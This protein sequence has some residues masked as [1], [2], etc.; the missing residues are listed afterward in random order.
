MMRRSGFLLALLC[1]AVLPGCNRRPLD[2]Q[3]FRTKV[4]VKVN[5]DAVS[6]V[7]CDIYN[8]KIPL[9]MIDPEVMRVL[10]FEEGSGAL[11]AE[12][13]ISGRS[14]D[15][16]DGKT[17]FSGE[18][19]IAPGSYRLLAYNFGT[20][21]TQ[22]RDPYDWERSEAY[23][24]PVP[25]SI[26]SKFA[27]KVPEGETV[28]YEPDHLVVARVPDEVIPPHKG[29]YTIKT[30]CRSV[31]ES[32]YLQI[33]VDGLQWVSSA[34]AVLSGLSSG[35]WISLGQRIDDPRNAVCFSLLKSD[36]KGEP[37]VC[38]I[39]STFG[40]PDG[41]QN[42]LEVTFDLRTTD[43]RTIQKSFDISGLFLTEDC[44]RHH[45]LLLDETIT[46]DPPDDPGHGGGF[47]P[48]VGDWDDEHHDIDL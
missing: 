2:D 5:V 44:I 15:G 29:V 11:A 16:D 30:E 13:F 41:S 3:D 36:D 24:N 45:W 27:T 4:Q 12:S 19:S 9:P 46:I 14:A 47:D 20:E 17:V 37:V 40:R 34:T 7:T 43:G 6:N 42:D 28:V 8:D 32:Y 38:A 26:S 39:F 31:V 1:I 25:E 22:V 10:F 21:T 33:K 48:S 18:V 35:N 23:T